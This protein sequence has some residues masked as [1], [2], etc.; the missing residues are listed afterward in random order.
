MDFKTMNI[1]DIMNWCVANKQTEWLKTFVSTPVAHKDY[2]TIIV[3]GK[4]VKDKSA[5]PKTVYEKP[6]YIEIRKAFVAKFMPEI[7]PKAKEKKPSMYDR[8]AAL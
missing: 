1:D 2:P 3:D 5:T 4:K 6:T 7:A 8:I